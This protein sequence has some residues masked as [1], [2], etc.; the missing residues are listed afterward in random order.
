MLLFYIR[1]GEP[2]YD[3]DSLTPLGQEQARAVAKRLC[4]HG[5]DRIFASSSNRAYQTAKPTADLLRKEITTLNWAH[6]NLVWK[7]FGVYFED[8]HWSWCD[9]HRPTEELFVSDEIKALG[10][11]WYEHPA[12][13]TQECYRDSHFKEGV[14]RV[15]KESDAFLLSLGYRHDHSRNGY[16]AEAPNDERIALFAHAG[17]AMSFFSSLLDIPYPEYATHFNLS[18]SGMCV[19]EFKNT[20]GLVVPRV[21]QYSN[22]SHLYAERLP[23]KYEN[24]IRF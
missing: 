22:D 10:K 4:T 13:S 20:D 3:P 12:F 16:I 11:K 2:I 8:G 9:S 24:R 1:H 18:H 7:E 6:E 19:L 17:F 23:L 14:E 21:L 15:Q 5:I